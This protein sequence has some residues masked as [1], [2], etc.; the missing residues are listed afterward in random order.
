MTSIKVSSHL[1]ELAADMEKIATKAERVML[2]TTREA[3]KV[4]NM[5]AKDFARASSGRHGKLYPRSFSAEL[6][7]AG[8]GLIAGEY[9]PDAEMPQG[10]MSFEWGSRNQK[11][12]L[13]L[14]RSADV[15]GGSFAREVG[16][17]IDGLFW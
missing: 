9:G 14:N 8:F 2:S 10:G 6:T 16:E 13:D 12:H 1:D 7:F 15:I 3:L 11:P 17:R 4:G 5:L